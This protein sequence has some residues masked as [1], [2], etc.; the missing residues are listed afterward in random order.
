MLITFMFTNTAY[1]KENNLIISKDT[2]KSINNVVDDSDLKVLIQNNVSALTSTDVTVS[3]MYQLYDINGDANYILAVFKE[4]GYA[5]VTGKDA[6]ISE[7]DLSTGSKYPYQGYINSG[8]IYA[9]PLNYIIEKDNKHIDANNGKS[10][11]L[12]VND[13]LIEKN[14]NMLDKEKKLSSFSTDL[15]NVAATTTTTWTGIPESNMTRYQNWINNDGTCGTYATFVMLVYCDDYFN[16]NYV[17]SSIR[18]RYSTSPGT[19][20]TQMKSFI[21]DT[22]S[23]TLAG[24][25]TQ[26]MTDYFA[27]YL[28]NHA[29][30][31]TTLFFVN[32]YVKGSIDVGKPAVVGLLSMLGSPYGDHWVTVYAYSVDYYKAHDNWGSITAII[33]NNWMTCGIWIKY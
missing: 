9:G 5:I 14:K 2:T 27:Y 11:D 29:P 17:P 30:D 23:G 6:I 20:I 10:F 31:E 18:T 24:D 21:G 4:G 3:K 16:D 19:L 12:S 22:G 7:C 28:I 15:V 26:G 1:G 8:L 13:K 25:I 33:N 32:T